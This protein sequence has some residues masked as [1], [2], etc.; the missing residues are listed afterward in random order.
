MTTRQTSIVGLIAWLL[1]VCFIA[2]SSPSPVFAL[3]PKSIAQDEDGREA[4]EKAMT[5]MS[6][7]NIQAGASHRDRR[8]ADGGY[9]GLLARIAKSFSKDLRVSESD[10][11]DILAKIPKT[12][13]APMYHLLA[14]WDQ[15]LPQEFR[16]L[17]GNAQEAVLLLQIC[18]RMAAHIENLWFATS[19]DTYNDLKMLYLGGANL[20]YWKENLGLET[21][22]AA[23]AGKI[24]DKLFQTIRT[25]IP[26]AEITA[27]H[28]KEQIVPAMHRFFKG[29]AWEPSLARQEVQ[30]PARN[31][32]DARIAAT[33]HEHFK[34]LMT[35]AQSAKPLRVMQLFTN[36]E[37]FGYWQNTYGVGKGV[38]NLAAVAY[39]QAYEY[40]LDFWGKAEPTAEDFRTRWIPAFALYFQ[41]RSWD[42]TLEGQ[43]GTL[44]VKFD[45][46]AVVR[47]ELE[48]Y[49]RDLLRHIAG[50]DRT[51]VEE[52]KQRAFDADFWLEKLNVGM[53]GAVSAK[54]MFQ[55]AYTELWG[56][57][58]SF[59]N[60]PEQF[61]KQWIPAYYKY[62]CREPWREVLRGT[63]IAPIPLS[64][65]EIRV[66]ALM[67]SHFEMLLY[68]ER[69]GM[70][71]GSRE[72]FNDGLLLKY[73]QDKFGVSKG[74]AVP[75]RNLMVEMDKEFMH[76]WTAN[77]PT[78]FEFRTRLLPAMHLYV[79][80]KPWRHM[81]SKDRQVVLP[82]RVVAALKA[83]NL[84][85]DTSWTQIDAI[86][87]RKLRQY[88][89]TAPGKGNEVLFAEISSQFDE[90]KHYR[91]FFEL[92]AEPLHGDPHIFADGTPVNAHDWEY[93]SHLDIYRKKGVKD[94][95][96]VRLSNGSFAVQGGGRPANLRSKLQPILQNALDDIWL[97]PGTLESRAKLIFSPTN[98]IKIEDLLARLRDHGAKKLHL[99]ESE[100]Q[101]LISIVE[102]LRLPGVS[103]GILERAT[104][105]RD[106]A[107][108]LLAIDHTLDP[109][110]YH[111]I[112]PRSWYLD[113][114]RR[115]SWH[116]TFWVHHHPGELSPSEIS[117]KTMEGRNMI[118][119]VIQ[120]KRLSNVWVI[121]EHNAGKC[122][123]P[124]LVFLD[125]YWQHVVAVLLRDKK[126]IEKI[127]TEEFFERHKGDDI[128]TH[129]YHEIPRIVRN[130]GEISSYSRADLIKIRDGHG[131]S[132]PWRNM[133]TFYANIPQVAGIC[134]ETEGMH[135]LAMLNLGLYK[136][137]EDPANLACHL[138]DV[139]SSEDFQKIKFVLNQYLLIVSRDDHLLDLL[140][141]KHEQYPGASFLLQR[142]QAHAWISHW[143]DAE[144]SSN[145]DI[146]KGK[147]D[148][149]SLGEKELLMI[150]VR[151]TL[152]NLV[153]RL[154]VISHSD[155]EEKINEAL[156]RLDIQDLR[157]LQGLI[158][159]HPY[160]PGAI[161]LQA[162]GEK[163]VFIDGGDE[164]PLWNNYVE[165][166]LAQFEEAVSQTLQLDSQFG[167]FYACFPKLLNKYYLLL[168]VY[169]TQ[170]MTPVEKRQFID[171]LF[172]S[173]LVEGESPTSRGTFGGF[174]LKAVAKLVRKISGKSI[175]AHL[176]LLEL[177]DCIAKM[178]TQSLDQFLREV[179]KDL[180]SENPAIEIYLQKWLMK[181]SQGLQR[182]LM[183]RKD[184]PGILGP[185]PLDVE[186][187]NE[188]HHAA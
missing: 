117:K 67:Q 82:P 26:E 30:F 98:S 22:E 171:A 52:F 91:E 20:A 11:Q 137:F 65:E 105:F 18:S 80:G 90:L 79:Q 38:A 110:P 37:R 96:A 23:L 143:L 106:R 66:R 123:F 28:M 63:E 172:G 182:D 161:L 120:E 129:F 146:L 99:N 33:L 54:T 124:S 21:S 142:G 32:E 130:I 186:T 25:K 39:I 13:I 148:F 150:P 4:W 118:L 131:I 60:T 34:M 15:R 155:V 140:V 180:A 95:V 5:S 8:E 134:L 29:E 183:H 47:D 181:I 6:D 72:M 163:G 1:G 108:I 84:E 50:G 169:L 178:A 128:V 45:E 113:P 127:F 116:T 51:K 162:M 44:P 145:G 49:F 81:L 71:T 109:D 135:D 132:S 187:R 179:A 43:K 86:F 41:G 115:N 177:N 184:F 31:T 103:A 55:E 17:P 158:I 87:R 9:R 2:T 89:P 12:Q 36:G 76:L 138:S 56:D 125:E 88:H 42:H 77:A 165:F 164:R 156:S 111:P 173:R 93:D 141:A 160:A 68:Q 159:R 16:A 107:S 144:P 168:E 114:Q 14:D 152:G 153:E 174:V 48:D 46:D 136:Y 175:H 83:W 97:P 53:A 59:Y 166:R 147:R 62:F 57:W 40:F 104:G 185:R 70:K 154:S 101:S 133:V 119:N 24:Y 73:W 10:L 27:A 170:D 151:E 69:T 78:L 188:I 7:P 112:K 167:H 75:A 122:V 19:E 85:P 35:D 100:L 176:G 139:T 102:K 157:E 94:V 126:Q 64:A 149:R 58:S 92:Q 121:L 74:L 61:L 3:A